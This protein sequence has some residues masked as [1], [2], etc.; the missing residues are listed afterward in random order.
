M[1]LHKKRAWEIWSNDSPQQVILNVAFEGLH[2]LLFSQ[3]DDQQTEL[4]NAIQCRVGFKLADAAN[5]FC[6]NLATEVF[7]VAVKLGYALAQS[8]MSHDDFEGLLQEALER[9]KLTDYTPSDALLDA[10]TDAGL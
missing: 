10:A 4:F 9:A 6:T 7:H 3:V 8:S 5:S 1:Q 2:R